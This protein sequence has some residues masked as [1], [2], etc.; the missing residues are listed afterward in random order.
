VDVAF[1]SPFEIIDLT[2]ASAL[3]ITVYLDIEGMIEVYDSGTP[4]DKSDD[5][6]VFASNFWERFSLDF[7]ITR[8]E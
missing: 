7:E 3:D 8:E 4:V 6:V 2:Q 5:V 1:L